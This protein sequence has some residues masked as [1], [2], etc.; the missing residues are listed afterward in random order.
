MPDTKIDSAVA[1]NLTNVMKD[2]TV[3]TERTDGPSDQK[4]T[5][6]FDY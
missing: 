5:T 4:E 1:S 2:F 3:S 6:W